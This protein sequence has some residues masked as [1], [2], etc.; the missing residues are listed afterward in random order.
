MAYKE[1]QPKVLRSYHISQA[2]F[3][4]CQ[5]ILMNLKHSYSLH[6]DN[7]REVVLLQLKEDVQTSQGHQEDNNKVQFKAK[8]HLIHLNKD[9]ILNRE[10][11]M[12]MERMGHMEPHKV[13]LHKVILQ[14]VNKDVDN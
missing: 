7:F 8:P 3:P 14:E 9:H 11:M 12:S 5:F 13:L 6:E 2:L 4:F 1:A 10:H